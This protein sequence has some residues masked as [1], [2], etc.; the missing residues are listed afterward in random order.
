[1]SLFNAHDNLFVHQPGAFVGLSA[2]T[3]SADPSLLQLSVRRLLILLRKIALQ[4]GT[5][6]VFA[7]N[8]DRFRQMVRRSFERL[9]TVLGQLGAIVNFQVVM[10][11][12][13]NTADDIANGRFIVQLLVAPT[14]PVEF[15]TV[16]LVRAG[17]GLLDVLEGSP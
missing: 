5:P 13:V 3:L 14:N 16:T 2:H 12:G 8:N 15:I 7:T 10:D 11:G 9:L 1:M 4:R 17:E 6:Y